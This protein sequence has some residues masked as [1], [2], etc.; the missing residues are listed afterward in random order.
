MSAISGKSVRQLSDKLFGTTV[1]GKAV[2]QV[3]LLSKFVVVGCTSVINSGMTPIIIVA[4]GLLSGILMVSMLALLVIF[5]T[6]RKYGKASLTTGQ[7]DTQ[8][9]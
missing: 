3:P 8:Y 5:C 6:R 7:A 9:Q 1:C 4:I 2:A